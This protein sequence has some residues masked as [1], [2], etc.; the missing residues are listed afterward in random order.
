V[1]SFRPSIGTF[2]FV[3]DKDKQ[4][5]YL[6][7]IPHNDESFEK[8]IVFASKGKLFVNKICLIYTQQNKGKL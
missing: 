2:K 1:F 8:E 5:N 3:F 7:E 4:R 6:R